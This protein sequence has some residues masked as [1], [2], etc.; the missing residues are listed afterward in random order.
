MSRI[1]MLLWCAFFIVPLVTMMVL[2]GFCSGKELCHAGL[3]FTI[4]IYAI[5]VVV[6]MVSLGISRFLFKKLRASA[7]TR[8][9]TLKALLLIPLIPGF[10]VLG[11]LF[12]GFLG[13][14]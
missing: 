1:G 11:L 13:R 2:D 6:F 3:S 12:A 14:L 5:A 8:I 9:L 10:I 7:R 4:L